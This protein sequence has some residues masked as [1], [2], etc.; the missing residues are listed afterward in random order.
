VNN[1]ETAIPRDPNPAG[2][3]GCVVTVCR[4]CCCGA[5]AKHPDVDH[6]RQLTQLRTGVAG[7]G[8]VRVSDCLDTCERSN[9][10]VVAPSPAGRRAGGRPVWLGEILDPDTTAAVTTWVTAGGP[11]LT[12]PPH[13][14]DPHIFNPPRQG[15]APRA[16]SPV[17]G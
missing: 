5:Q 14:L 7:H 4:G 6:A 8:R 13:T 9:V 12:D 16:G 15:R 11:G 17:V 2:S 3:N 1:A 10:L